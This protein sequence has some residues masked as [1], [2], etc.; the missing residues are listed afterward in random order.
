MK[1]LFEQ[2]KIRNTYLKNRI[3]VPP[4]V[5]SNWS[6]DTGVVSDEHVNHYDKISKGNF[7]MIIQEATCVAKDGR[8]S[9]TQLGIWS[10]EH[11]NGL[12]R[13]VDTVHKNNCPI[14]VQI[15]HA[16]IMYFGDDLVCPSDYALDY[17]GVKKEARALTKDE[18]KQ[19]QKQFVEAGVRAFSLGY[20]G[21][22]LHGCHGYLMSQFLNDRVNKRDDEYGKDRLL[23]VT[24]IYEQL[25]SKTS[26]DFIIGIR[27]GGFEPTLS[28]SIENAKKL[29]KLG[30][31]YINVSYGF[32]FESEP[33]KPEGFELPDIMYASK[34][35]KEEV[36]VPVFT[37]L[38]IKSKEDAQK[39]LDIT[40]ADM[41]NVGRGVLVNYSWGVDAED[42]NDTGKCYECS[43]C[44]W[45]IDNSKCVG[46]IQYEKSKLK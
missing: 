39:A 13:I 32:S 6:D 19:I 22:E 38:G 45:R 8:L 14:L 28:H 20:D 42:G 27:L 7:G 44:Q 23:F 10:D 4:M 46:K 33:F 18:I 36:D 24:E 25:R 40:N 29:E 1:K 35:I 12:K 21:V 3:V 37:V 30:V 26:D 16:G 9:D 34:C 11:N 31:D 17:K 2:V 43:V 5:I 41:V 15:H